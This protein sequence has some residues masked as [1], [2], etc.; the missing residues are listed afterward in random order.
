[1]K[2][3]ISMKSIQTSVRHEILVNKSL[4]IGHLIPVRSKDEAMKAYRRIKDEHTDATH[5]CYAFVIGQSQN[6][7]KYFDDGEP[8]RTAGLPMIEVLLKNEL[9][10]VLAVSVRYYG[11]IKLG[12]GG[13]ARAYGKSISETLEEAKFVWLREFQLLKVTIPFD[14]IGAVEQP[15]RDRHT[16]VN[17]EYDESVHYFVQ[18]ATDDVKAFR[19]WIGDQ[20]SGVASIQVIKTIKAYQ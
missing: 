10:D 7:Q 15:L 18:L 3:V 20:T 13:L 14:L 8:T 12:A 1:M 16:L 6:E 19:T 5:H 9:T 11:G 4:F 17:T 2:M